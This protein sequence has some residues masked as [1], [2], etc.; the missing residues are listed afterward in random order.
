LDAPSEK[1]DS[2]MGP[3]MYYSVLGIPNLLKLISESGCICRHLEYDQYPALHLYII[4]QRGRAATKSRNS[5][6]KDAKAA[7]F[8]VYD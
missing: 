7:K 5:S 1:V 3:Q 6:R 8:E 4:A 2:A